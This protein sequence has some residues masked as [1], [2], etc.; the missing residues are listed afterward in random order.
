MI[1]YLNHRRTKF[2]Y[3][4][5]RTNSTVSLTFG[6]LRAFSAP[7]SVGQY[8]WHLTC[9]FSISLFSIRIAVDFCSQIISQKWPTVSSRGPWVRIY[10]RLARS[11]FQI[12]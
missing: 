7:V 1:S 5:Q 3:V 10:C 9:F 8:R 11:S 12:K 2:W 4:S 6:S